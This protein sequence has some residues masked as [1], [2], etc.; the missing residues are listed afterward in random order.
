MIGRVMMRRRNRAL[1]MAVTLLVVGLA[2]PLYYRVGWSRMESHCAAE[3]PGKVAFAE[4]DYSFT[5]RG[6]TC[7]YDNGAWAETAYWFK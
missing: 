6:F 4:V 5:S 1:A 2:L 7:T 3:S